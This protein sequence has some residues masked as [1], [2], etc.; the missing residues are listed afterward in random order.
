MT[1]TMRSQWLQQRRCL[2]E[3]A[4]TLA[5]VMAAAAAA[6]G[7]VLLPRAAFEDLLA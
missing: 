3:A 4:M 2:P 1:M 7:A 5:T 6:P